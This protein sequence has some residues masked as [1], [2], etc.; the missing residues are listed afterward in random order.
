MKYTPETP[1]QREDIER[2]DTILK[3]LYALDPHEN[4][5]LNHTAGRFQPGPYTPAHLPEIINMLE[6]AITDAKGNIIPYGALDE[7]KKNVR[8]RT[9]SVERAEGTRTGRMGT[10][11]TSDDA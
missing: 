5:I 3:E 4:F 2:R 11:D 7:P 9:E 10:S 6:S 1:E 8:H